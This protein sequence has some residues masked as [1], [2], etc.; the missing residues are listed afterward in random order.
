MTRVDTVPSVAARKG[1]LSTGPVQ[2]DP[3]VAQFLNAF[4]PLPNG[5]ALGNGD[6]GIFSFADQQVTTE[7][8]FT[9]KI[10]RKFSEHDS[11]AGTYLRDN[12]KQILPDAFDWLLSNVVSQ[13][14]L[15]TLLEQHIFSPRLLNAARAGFNRAVAVNGGVSQVMN[16]LLTDPK[17][18]FVPGRIR[19]LGPGCSRAYRLP[20]RSEPGATQRL[21]FVPNLH[22]ELIPGGR[23]CLLHK[24]NPCRAIW[25]AGRADAG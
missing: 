20:G 22:L 7:N 19:R 15:V 4:Y 9:T 21:E 3:F 1:Q 11:L 8:Y 23:R 16:P 5:P 24:G 18:G 25:G 13:R 12:S 2:V 17:F 6:T 14:Q 10:D